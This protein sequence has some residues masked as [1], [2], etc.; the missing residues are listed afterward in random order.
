M[1]QTIQTISALIAVI[2]AATGC[3][4]AYKGLPKDRAAQ[5]RTEANKVVKSA[6][7]IIT[8]ALLVVIFSIE[9]VSTEP[10]TRFAVAKMSITASLFS[11]WVIIHLL[12][13]LISHMQEQTKIAKSHLEV[14]Q[15]I[16]AHLSESSR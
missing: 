10:L 2:L 7:F 3:W 12:Q 16:T 5:V 9:A 4:L 6:I 8:A 1:A 11:L 13:L 14:T 15:L